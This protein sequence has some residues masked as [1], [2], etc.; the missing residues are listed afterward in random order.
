MIHPI[1]EK[2]A[3]LLTEYCTNVQEGENVLLFIE[4]PAESIA[5]A[6]TRQ[7]LK[8]G[9]NPILRLTYPEFEQDLYELGN[10]A[11]FSHKPEFELNEIK[12]IDAWIRIRAPQNTKA[13]QNA[14]KDKVAAR[15]RQNRDIQ[16][17]R[18]NDTKWVGTLYPTNALAQDADMSLEAYEAFVYGAMFLLDDDPVAKWNEIH[19]FQ[20]K[21]IERLKTASEV[22]IKG[23]G[24]DLKMNVKDRIWVNSAGHKNMPSGE[25][26][27]GPIESSA[28]GIISYKIPSSVQGVEVNDIQ[29]T[30]KDGKVVDAKAKKGNDLLQA[31]LNADEGAR[32]L[33]ELGI[34]TNFNIQTP[35]KQ[36]LYDE[37]IGGTIHLALGQ[38]YPE[39]LG[40]N[41]S[42]IHWDMICDLRQGGA[43]Y[44][45]GELF[46]E[47]G[48][49]KI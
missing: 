29:L 39:T 34:G 4:T 40:I 46:Q 15:L 8:M 2:W 28:N 25:V 47:N 44:L 49:F 19:A 16:N 1:H 41:E 10:D 27:T 33:G 30:F 21:L 14:S 42:A 18:L 31:Q 26:F 13:L 7:V 24:T 20:A 17:I 5:R 32:F 23:D 9:A 38:S 36:I 3:K 11:Y 6:L 48:E 37:K 35:T 12:Q 22:H 45:D 43:I